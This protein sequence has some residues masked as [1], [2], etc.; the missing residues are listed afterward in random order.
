MRLRKESTGK[1]TVDSVA[2]R[3]EGGLLLLDPGKAKQSSKEVK[4]SSSVKHS[5]KG[6]VI[7]CDEGMR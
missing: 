5:S 2:A 6:I 4:H 1:G 3:K 7:M